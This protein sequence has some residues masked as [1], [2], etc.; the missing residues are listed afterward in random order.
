VALIGEDRP[1][2]RG[3]HRVRF[4]RGAASLLTGRLADARLDLSD[5]AHAGT[6]EGALWLAALA[7]LEDSGSDAPPVG[8][9][10]RWLP[11]LEAYPQPI[12][13]ALARPLAEATLT[14]G[15]V[16]DAR[17]LTD[18]LAAWAVTARERAWLPYLQGRLLARQGKRDKAIAAWAETKLDP[19]HP[20]YARTRFA[21]I[22]LHLADNTLGPREALAEL[23]PLR[24]QW[25]G[26]PFEFQV[27]RRLG[28][29][30]IEAG[31]H[32]DG[33]RTL[34]AAARR[35]K[36]LP[37]AAE[38]TREVAA[39]FERLAVGDLA[40]RLT[41]MQAI[42]L[43]RD[44]GTLMPAG[45]KRRALVR[46]HV[47]RLMAVDLLAEAAAVLEHEVASAPP[48][49]ERAADG[50]RLAEVY[51]RDGRPEA[52]LA[53]LARSVTEPL[54]AGLLRARGRLEARA[55]AALGQG[56]AALALLKDEDDPE[57]LR[58]RTRILR[59]REDW[60]GTGASLD[61]QLA[62]TQE[63]AGQSSPPP[64]TVLELAAALTLAREPDAAR[65]LR[66]ERGHDL[67]ATPLAEAF[68]VLTGGLPP[69]G[70]DADAL[71]AYVAEAEA[72][73]QLMAK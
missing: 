45:E 5:A 32:A 29:L 69:P 7:A 33:L 47:E 43:I 36:A 26:D 44:F 50:L 24:D 46:R 19:S 34:D 54:P 27:L 6:D 40:D 12:R 55:R 22:N 38:L 41:P 49:P 63:A 35:F 66:A 21:R 16:A 28:R 53:A 8:A 18:A 70:A 4:L 11:I 42:A 37:D 60:A 3:E 1:A 48:D 58:L 72:V 30:Q 68:K 15:S 61:R 62:R 20:A 56:D 23:D 52:A 67:A 10:G 14:K 73:R 25:R 31:D 17:R 13:F 2:A 9:V 59:D 71:K 65:R 39:S 57:S 64:E 51:S